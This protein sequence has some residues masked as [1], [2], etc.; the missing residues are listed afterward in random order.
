[1]TAS[2]QTMTATE[3][4]AWQTVETA[5][6]CLARKDFE[7]FFAHFHP[8]FVGWA[9]L[10]AAPVPLETRRKWVPFMYA[11]V[12]IVEYEVQPLSVRIYDDR[13]AICHYLSFKAKKRGDGSM[14]LEKEKWSD[15]LLKSGDRWLVISDSG[16]PVD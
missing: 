7:A 14:Q 5:T 11:S 3:R 9:S 6:E 8:D 1:M 2:L 10:R 12:Q 16:G 15:V 13:V 4:E